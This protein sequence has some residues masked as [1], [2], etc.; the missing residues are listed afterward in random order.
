ML[1]IDIGAQLI[2]DHYYRV[3]GDKS[4]GGTGTLR[5]MVL[6]KIWVAC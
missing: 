5:S 2:D 6:I 3:L 1:R 4:E